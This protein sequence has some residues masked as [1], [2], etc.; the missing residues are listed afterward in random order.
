VALSDKQAARFQA[1]DAKR[2][3]EDPERA[4]ARATAQPDKGW[5]SSVCA[6]PE[7]GL[8]RAIEQHMRDADPALARAFA[9]ERARLGGNA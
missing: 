5:D 1:A 4:A 3:S 2:L 7:E 6:E 9:E 8:R